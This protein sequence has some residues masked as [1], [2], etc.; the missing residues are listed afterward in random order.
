[1]TSATTPLTTSVRHAPISAQHPTEAA[2]SREDSVQTLLQRGDHL[3]KMGDPTKGVYVIRA[4]AIKSYT[5]SESGDQQILG[6]HL[7]GDIIGFDGFANGRN[8]CCAQALDTSSVTLVTFDQL[9]SSSG[10]QYQ[11]LRQ[12]VFRHISR[13]LNRDSELVLLLAKKTAE[14]RLAWFLMQF[15]DYLRNRGLCGTE[16][17]L[18]MSRTD[19]ANYLG[20]AMETV[21]REF[22]K[23]KD[24]NILQFERRSVI[25]ADSECLRGLVDGELSSSLPPRK[26]VLH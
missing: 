9:F 16:F 8:Q 5:I 4:G 24:R 23:L 2:Q 15:S 12:D 1:M 13:G 17:S 11:D 14:Q 6:F 20:L 26:G 3:Y 19:I 7:T 10:T 18:P 22:A 25:I 21:C